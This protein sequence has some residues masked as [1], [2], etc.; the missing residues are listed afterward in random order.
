M[1]YQKTIDRLRKSFAEGKTKP[2]A[3]R[4]AQLNNLLR[5]HEEGEDE[6]R[7]NPMSK[8]VKFHV[9]KAMSFVGKTCRSSRL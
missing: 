4:K 8:M 9:E 5:L 3:Y 7:P 1:T 6:V 2:L